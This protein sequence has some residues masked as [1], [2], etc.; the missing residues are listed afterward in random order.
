MS[1]ANETIADRRPKHWTKEQYRR[2]EN[3]PRAKDEPRFYLFRGELIEMSGMN[4]P[5]AWSVSK[6]TRWAVKSFDP[7]FIIRPQLPFDVPGDSMP[8]PDVAIVAPEED[9]RPTHPQSAALVIEIAESSLQDDRAMAAEYASAGVPQYWILD[10][11]R[12]VLEI[13]TQII[14]EPQS[15]TGKNYGNVR[16][17]SENEIAETFDPA[18]SVAVKE[19]LP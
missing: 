16:T 3:V 18:I 17:L 11:K 10:V 4:Q 2:L 13:R 12:R 19:L 7:R 6:C 9:A 8:E 1:L 15:P 14:D 5:H